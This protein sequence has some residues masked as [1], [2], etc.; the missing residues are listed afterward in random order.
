[1]GFKCIHIADVHFRG[2]SRH[3]EYRESF[4]DLFRQA[5]ALKPDVIFVGGDIVHSKTQGISPELIDI[6]S[7]WF[8]GLAEIA[9]THVILGNHDGLLHNK[10][11]QDAI[12]PIVNALD[13]SRLFL[14]KNSGVY[15]T[16]IDGYNWCVFSCF[17]EENWDIVKPEAG[18]VNI[19]VYHG[20]VH[21]SL[22]DVDWSIDGDVDFKM[23]SE[24][25]FTFLG[26][27]HKQQ[28]LDEEKRVAYSGS[29]IQ[30]NYGE[31]PGKG[32]LF[33]DIDDVDHYDSRFYPV[34]HTSPFVTID[35]VGDVTTTLDRSEFAPDGSRF[36]IRVKDKISQAEIKQLHSALKEFK[37]ATEIVFKHEHTIDPQLIQ[38]SDG[39][40][41]KENLRDSKTH[42]G[43]MRQYYLSVDITDD[44]WKKLDSLVDRYLSVIV[45]DD[46]VTR[47][48]KWQL[49]KI[50]FDNTFSYGKGNI[51][52]FDNMTGITGIFGRNRLGKSSIPGTIMYGLFNTTDRGSVKNLHVINTRK[53]HC[54]TTIDVSVNGNL[55]RVGRQT[56]RYQTKKGIVH[57]I[58]HMNLSKIDEGGN[59][60]QD[61]SGEQRRETEK[62]LRRLVGTPDD[63]LLTALASQ[64]EMNA[65][66]KHKATKRKEIL[67]N[68]LDLGIFEHM[69]LLAKEDSNSTR[70]L[71]K[72][73]PEHDWDS[74]IEQK[75]RQRL[76]KVNSRSEIEEQLS[77]MRL[78][79]QELK[80]SLA[81]HKDKDIVTRDDV[82]AQEDKIAHAKEKL[83]QLRG[84]KEKLFTEI[85]DTSRKLTKIHVLKDQFPLNELRERLSAQEKIEKILGD[86]EH[87][88]EKEK[89]ILRNQRKSIQ[90]LLEV[91][92]G[93]SFPT[94]KFI[95]ESH[96]NKK[97]VVEQEKKVD[98]LLVEIRSAKKSASV[99]REQNLKEKLRRYDEILGQESDLK[100]IKSKKE[101][102][103]HKLQT[104]SAN[105][106]NLIQSAEQE[107]A[108]M[109]LRVS[110]SEISAAI[111]S[112]KRQIST[113]AA[114]ISTLDANRMSLSESIGLLANEI[115]KLG[116]EKE[117]Y[118]N[119]LQ[120]WR[121]YDLFMTAVSKKGIPLQIIASQLPIINQEIAKILQGV[122]GFTVELEAESGSSVMDVYINYGDSRRI[123][124]CASGMEK[125]ISSLAIRVALTN[126]SSLPKTDVLIIDE[127]FGALDEMNVEACNRLLSSLK[128]WFKNILV[129]SHVD[130]VKDAVDNVLDITSKGKDAKVIYE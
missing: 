115:T 42:H 114:E 37:G 67:T 5:R 17:D 57:G 82:T 15:P 69:L 18:C 59:I 106:Q 96:R 34:K 7:W 113:M 33:W 24:F 32:F 11:R 22:T 41:F 12:T 77:A 123:I 65:F 72:N 63:F 54:N 49:K 16:G 29:T 38:T 45:K 64:G 26:D 109:R 120:Q 28:Y 62:T 125:M 3:E 70:V 102:S 61:L 55:Y 44:E 94:C 4:N 108:D 112:M 111:S 97:L 95:K 56:T 93:N 78:K 35:W 121:L 23:F 124:E 74:T 21:G 6:L 110:D 88:R 71:L 30:Q 20:A 48:V 27:I 127:G 79:L 2:L 25:D 68:F 1:M 119:L 101:M 130:A 13:N 117:K 53:G 89:M 84:K 9:P 90:K 40:F 87:E 107:V 60:L 91:P 76:L 43:L 52:N 14:Y 128:R 98:L 19:A 103:V 92:C 122:V 86:L 99:L 10:H 66:I 129:I 39:T 80:I 105:L 58:T 73:V 118:A 51:I 8:T 81:T 46:Q 83:G 50:E 116:T 85:E 36:R 31:T 100:V 126:I 104:E 75:E 47:N